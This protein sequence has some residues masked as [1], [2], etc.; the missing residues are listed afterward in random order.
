[1][2]LQFSDIPNITLGHAQ[3]HT[4]LTGC[5]V[6]LTPQCAP[7]GV[8]IG[9]GGPASRE[10]PLCGPFAAAPGIHAL[11]LS[12]GSAF[13]L[14]AADGVMR[15]LRERGV[16]VDCGGIKV[17]LVCQSALFDLGIGN[18]EAI[19]TAEMAYHACLAA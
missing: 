17:P 16:G 4:G 5:T 1:M 15:Y 10:T 14:G 18:P 3:D 11:L 13:S 2:T 19:P 9:G 8:Y 12:G 7:A 6:L